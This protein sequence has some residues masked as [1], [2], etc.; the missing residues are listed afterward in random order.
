MTFFWSPF[1]N[2]ID[3]LPLS[4]IS[5]V[6]REISKGHDKGEKVFFS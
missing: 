1:T 3:T 2:L 6:G 5:E 4:I